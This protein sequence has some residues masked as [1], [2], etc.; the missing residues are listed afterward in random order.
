MDELIKKYPWV[1]TLKNTVIGLAIIAGLAYFITISASEAKKDLKDIFAEEK[2]DVTLVEDVLA[3]GYD[4]EEVIEDG[5]KKQY[6][7]K[8]WELESRIVEEG[9]DG[10]KSVAKEIK[11]LR[12][13][14]KGELN[15]IGVGDAAEYNKSRDELKMY[16]NVHVESEDGSTILNTETLI[17]SDAKDNK[18]MSCP[19]PVELWVDDNHILADMMFSDKDLERIDF[20]GRV[21]MFN[22][23]IERE[24][25]MTREGWIDFE[26]VKTEG[27][28]DPD[29]VI[30][31]E[32]EY[33]HYDK[34]E[35]YMECY[36]YVPHRVKKRHRTYL[37]REDFKPAV[38]F[39]YQQ[40]SAEKEE[41]D[42]IPESIRTT[43][44]EGFEDIFKKDDEKKS[45]EEKNI[46]EKE[47]SENKEKEI[48]LPERELRASP[49]PEPFPGKFPGRLAR[50]V[51]CWKQDKK[52]FSNRL[53]INLKQKMLKPRF[54][55]Y[56]WAFKMEKE[57]KKK[58]DKKNEEP[59]KTVKALAKETTEIF[60][61]FMNVYWKTDFIDAW[62]GIEIRQKEKYFTS[63]NMVY[64]D[65]LG[66]MEADGDVFMEQLDGEWLEREG[67][68]E[69]MTD[70]DAKEHAKKPTEITSDAMISYDDEDYVYMIGNVYIKQEEQNIVSNEGEFSDSKDIMVF[71]GNVKYRNKDGERLNADKLTLY[72]EENRY[73]AEGAVIARSLVPEE[74]EDDLR[75][76]EGEDVEPSEE[77]PEQNADEVE[78]ET[79]S[80]GESGD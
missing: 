5:V 68:L 47:S 38:P 23:G 9:S 24:N 31:V 72:T 13:Y 1:L 50:Q 66:I 2:S 63:E 56:I 19:E 58:H 76:M 77:N 34:I 43:G 29:D 22:I 52:I 51:Y 17:W 44:L 25:F 39:K 49:V 64:S 71:W 32:C 54:D 46:E 69:D 60:G 35:K 40:Q 75:E 55:V 70:E 67:L 53:D 36:P 21:S 8:V 3:T 37:K 73:I 79:K 42:L 20:L 11:V 12:I 14:K 4:F 26:D 33:I 18:R 57:V 45:D 7:G 10:S 6:F 16:G 59:S 62:G 74:Y 30:N 28:R 61:D 78:K 41:D 27:E 80:E 48:E 15:L 65:E